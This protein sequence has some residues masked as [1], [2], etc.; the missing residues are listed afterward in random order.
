MS[1]SELKKSVDKLINTTMKTKIDYRRNV[2]DSVYEA[3]I[4][5]LILKAFSRIGGKVYLRSIN[6]TNGK[7]PTTFLFR[8]SPGNIHSRTYDFGHA[9]VHY[10][11]KSYEV[12][13]GVFHDGTSN[14]R[15]E[16]D[17]SII[18]HSHCKNC[19]VNLINPKAQYTKS[20]FECKYYSTHLGTALIR[21]FVG[22]KDDMGSLHISRFLANKEAENISKYCSGKDNRPRFNGGL[23]PKSQEEELFVHALM[24][25]LKKW[26]G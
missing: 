23:L 9:E 4:F 13:L 8:G 5:S 18:E 26:L 22:L 1:K 24:D 11:E 2:E 20:I 15:H 3:F 16:V 25:D 21:T 14:V 6:N 12:H 7:S 17:V 19:R 10:N